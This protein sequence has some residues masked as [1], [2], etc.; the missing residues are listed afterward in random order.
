MKA[1]YAVFLR[2]DR[3]KQ[4]EIGALGPKKFSP[5]VYVYI[6]SAMNSVEK[7]LERHY[8]P[9][10]NKHW[11]IDYLSEEADVFDHFILPE[12]SEYECVLAEL[13]SSFTESVPGFG[14][15]DCSCESHLFRAPK[16]FSR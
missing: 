10:E 3:E 8:A 16:N 5:G 9:T 14:S 7:R 11:H 12:N 6:G 2:L 13:F 1:V 15:S 4:I